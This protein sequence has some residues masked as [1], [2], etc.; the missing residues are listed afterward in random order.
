VRVAP[1][2]KA[3]PVRTGKLSGLDFMKNGSVVHDHEAAIGA[4]IELFACD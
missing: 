2:K 3:P 4:I 1:N